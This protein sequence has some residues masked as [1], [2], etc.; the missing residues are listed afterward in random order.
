MREYL[1]E[2]SRGVCRAR[3]RTVNPIWSEKPVQH[4]HSATAQN[5]HRSDG[6]PLHQANDLRVF[7]EHAH[8]M[9]PMGS[10]ALKDMPFGD[11]SEP[12]LLASCEKRWP[13]GDA[14]RRWLANRTPRHD[15]K[16]HE[17]QGGNR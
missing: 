10:C 13:Q 9:Q 1:T 5:P 3:R 11:G 7:M 14:A 15:S 12:K 2:L 16:R 17:T 6:S 8:D 4:M